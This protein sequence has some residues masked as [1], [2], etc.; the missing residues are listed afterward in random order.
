[1]NN[2]NWSFALSDD[3]PLDKRTYLLG[4]IMHLAY[5]NVT[6]QGEKLIAIDLSDIR[7]LTKCASEGCRFLV[8]EGLAKWID[9]TDKKDPTQAPNSIS[10]GTTSDFIKSRYY[11]ED[12]VVGSLRSTGFSDKVVHKRKAGKVK[13]HDFSAVMDDLLPHLNSYREYCARISRNAMYATV[14]DTLRR[15]FDDA[16]HGKFTPNDC[17]DYLDCVN[18]IVYDRTDIEGGKKANVKIRATAKSLIEKYNMEKIIKL[19][20]YFV[21]NYPN[22]ADPKYMDTNIFMLNMKFTS[23]QLM[24][25]RVTKTS[26]HTQKDYDNDSL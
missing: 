18:A 4:S 26:S 5:V 10:I 25:D 17:I 21:V 2:V 12:I 13:I 8:E 15:I 19:V 20:P 16:E 23:M 9:T 22:V 14:S 24:M 7:Q 11:F 3:F 1:M 6:E